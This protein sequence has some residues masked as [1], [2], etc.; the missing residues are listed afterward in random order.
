VKVI[1]IEGLDKSGK[2]TQSN[3]LVQH[4]EAIGYRVA[5]SEFHRYDTPT[6]ELIMRWLKKEWDVDQTTIE[7]IMT[8]DKQAQQKW[9]D[10]LEAQGVDFLILDRYTG[11]QDVYSY[12]NGIDPEWTAWLQRYMR[13]IDVEIFIDIPPTESMSR[14]GKHNNG[15]N[16]RYE[17]DLE[18][19]TRV[20]ELYL[21][22]DNIVIN[23]M[24][25]VES[26]HL[27]IVKSLE[28]GIIKG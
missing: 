4:L 10:E 11:S 7:L 25:D 20:R 19:L 26:V 17:S 18:L 12:A 27:D 22:R 14:K 3:W 8:A 21:E 9:F 5:K 16:D 1:A 23:G 28:S 24:Q 15:E 2:F 6:G 13:E